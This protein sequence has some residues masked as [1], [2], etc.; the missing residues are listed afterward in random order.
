MGEEALESSN[1]VD[2]I[3]QYLLENDVLAIAENASP[4][5]TAK[6]LACRKTSPFPSP[7]KHR[8]LKYS[9]NFRLTGMNNS[10]VIVSPVKNNRQNNSKHNLEVSSFGVC[11]SNRQNRIATFSPIEIL[12]SDDSAISLTEDRMGIYSAFIACIFAKDLKKAKHLI[13]NVSKAVEYESVEVRQRIPLKIHQYCPTVTKVDA[14]QFQ[15]IAQLVDGL[16]IK[17][18]NSNWDEFGICQ[19]LIPVLQNIKQNDKERFLYSTVQHYNVWRNEM[20][21]VQTCLRHIAANLAVL[22][23]SDDPEDQQEPDLINEPCFSMEVLAKLMEESSL[24]GDYSSEEAI[25]LTWCKHFA[26][27]MIRMLVDDEGNLKQMLGND[28][29]FSN[30]STNSHDETCPWLNEIDKKCCKQSVEYHVVFAIEEI[31]KECGLHGDLVEKLRCEVFDKIQ[32]H[33]AFAKERKIIE[34]T[35]KKEMKFSQKAKR[36]ILP[37]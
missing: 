15:M 4:N 25:V 36:V 7:S 22:Y 26:D 13:S 28:S 11:S 24:E 20:F 32:E 12:E 23:G 14:K 3:T 18:Q 21:W 19:R 9:M 2:D 29:A 16:M 31:C 33:V 6:Y 34:K 35:K 8:I 27:L 37:I 17:E 30:Y 1:L 5:V 10:L